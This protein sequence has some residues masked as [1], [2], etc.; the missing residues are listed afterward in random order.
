MVKC[1]F[2]CRSLL[3]LWICIPA[4]LARTVFYFPIVE[5]GEVEDTRF[6]TTIVL[7]NTGEERPVTLEFFTF[8]DAPMVLSLSG[9]GSASRFSIVLRGGESSSA[10]TSGTGLLQLGYAVVTSQVGVAGVGGTAVLTR[11]DP[12]TGTI[13]YEAEVAASKSLTNFGI[14]AD[15]PGVGRWVAD[16]SIAGQV[17][18]TPENIQFARLA[19]TDVPIPQPPRRIHYRATL[20]GSQETPEVMTDAS[21]TLEPD[22]ALDLSEAEFELRISQLAGVDRALIHCGPAG[23][24][25]PAVAFLFPG[26]AVPSIFLG[27]FLIARGTLTNADIIPRPVG[28][29]KHVSS[30]RKSECGLAINN[31][32]S[33]LAAVKQGCAYVN[34]YTRTRQLGEIRGQISEDY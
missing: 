7:V 25:G 2:L 26:P 1:A 20:S 31:I 15:S 18:E 6:Q 30:S 33:L 23:Q 5:N 17:I 9:L 3:V 4:V 14:F 11:S 34:V 16:R 12:V 8:D 22:F 27:G 29:W 21:G 28:Y 13:L 10:Q 24:N 32:A 19:T